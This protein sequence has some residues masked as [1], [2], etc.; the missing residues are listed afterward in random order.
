MLP[1]LE[2]F[3]LWILPFPH[4]EPHRDFEF[5]CYMQN[6]FSFPSSPLKA[7][8]AFWK[9]ALHVPDKVSVT[10][11]YWISKTGWFPKLLWI[12]LASLGLGMFKSSSVNL[13]S[14]QDC[15]WSPQFTVKRQK[16]LYSGNC[17]S[18]A[19]FCKFWSQYISQKNIWKQK[20]QIQI[21]WGTRGNSIQ[22]C[23]KLLLTNSVN[24]TYFS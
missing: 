11:S 7:F 8:L 5:F 21:W 10:P 2:P 14:H 19:K 16:N 6:M 1:Y 18:F 9:L 20:P 22:L 24:H 23:I 4:L 15:Q 17:L 3:R 12:T 13:K